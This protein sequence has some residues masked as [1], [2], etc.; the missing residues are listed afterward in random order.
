MAKLINLTPHEITIISEEGDFRLTP[1]GEV[2]RATST[3]E[4]VG[5]VNGIE[6]VKSTFGSVTGLPEPAEDT[7]Y[8]VSL[9]VLQALKGQRTDV[10]G[11]D[12]GPESAVRDADGRIVGVKRFQRL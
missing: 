1:S 6:V 9:L 4:V 3:T 12:T 10:V 8:I 11:P 7:I 2:A 5:E